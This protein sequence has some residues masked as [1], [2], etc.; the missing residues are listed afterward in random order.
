MSGSDWSTKNS[1]NSGKNVVGW[2]TAILAAEQEILKTKQRLAGLR[3]ALR[4]FR[5]KLAEGEP[6]PTQKTIEGTSESTRGLM[7]QK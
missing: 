4:T 5:K 1:T 6:W 7:G 2:D 3:A